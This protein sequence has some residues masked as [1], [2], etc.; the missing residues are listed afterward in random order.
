MSSLVFLSENDFSIQQGKKGYILCT[1]LP[2]I[3]LVLFYSK[4][5]NSC[6]DTIPIFQRLPQLVYGCQF[7]LLN[8]SNNMGVV[9]MSNKTSVPLTHVPFIILYVNGKPFMKYN[10]PKTLKD[11]ANFVNEVLSRIKS[12]NN[13]SSNSRVDIEDE[14][15]DYS[16]GIPFNLKCESEICY[17]TFNQAYK[18]DER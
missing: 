12:T 14:I 18:K 7:S 13:F 8:V 15:P 5:C 10:G 17:L 9:A 16:I 1:N 11:I 4:Q 3:S 6:N 2:S